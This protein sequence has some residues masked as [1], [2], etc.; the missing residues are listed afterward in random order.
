V[1]PREGRAFF[2][3]QPAATPGAIPWVA[4]NALGSGPAS[5]YG[6]RD[7]WIGKAGQGERAVRFVLLSGVFGV[8]TSAYSSCRLVM[9]PQ[10]DPTAAVHVATAGDWGRSRTVHRAENFRLHPRCERAEMGASP[11]AASTNDLDNVGL[12]KPARTTPALRCSATFR[13]AIISGRGDRYALDYVN[14]RSA[15]TPQAAG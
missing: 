11:A 1:S 15:S 7:K 3:S 12:Q 9:L 5:L 8:T 2:R 4:A 10:S 14:Q 6:P 13:S